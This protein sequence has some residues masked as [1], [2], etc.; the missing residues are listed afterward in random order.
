MYNWHI[1]EDFFLI[2]YQSFKNAV[3]GKAF[4]IDG[5]FGAQCWDGFAKYMID[6]GYRAV[7]CTTSQ[8]VK[9]IWNN[10]K[11]NGILNYCNEVT[12]MQPGDIAVFKEV[13]L[14]TPYSHVAI[15]D[16]DAGGGYG[17]FLGQN[18]GGKNGAFTLCKLPYSATFDTA[19]RP[20]CFVN[21]QT[22]KPKPQSKEAI[23][24]ILHVGSYVTS[25]QMK[26]GNQGLKKINNDTCAYLSQ[27]GGW[28]PLSMI[29]KVRGSDGY[30]DNVLHTTNAV[31]YVDRVRVD[32]INIPKNLAKIGGIWVSATPLIEVA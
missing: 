7:H 5:F 18:Q 30:N 3:L 28:F 25:V 8:F 9:D 11:T 26:I 17:W 31:V 23:D 21:S 2:N 6:L 15:F 12:V 19:F 13:A 14:W 32:E 10:R 4:D 22:A 27:L 24:Q 20:K 29:T 1:K 16:H